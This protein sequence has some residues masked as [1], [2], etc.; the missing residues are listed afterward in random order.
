VKGLEE[1]CKQLEVKGIRFD[2]PF[3]KLPDV[4]LAV[5]FLTDPWGTLIELTEGLDQAR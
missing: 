4:P 2:S 1:Y 3:H 5:A